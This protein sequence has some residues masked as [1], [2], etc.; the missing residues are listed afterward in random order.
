MS[1]LARQQELLLQALFEW[2]AQNAMKKIAAHAIDAGA[3][4][5]KA[6]QTNGHMLAE[7][8][9][10]AA[11]PVVTQVVGTQSMADLSRALWHAHPPQSGDLALWG[12]ELPVFLEHSEQL[13]DVPFLADVSRAEWALHRCAVAPDGVSDLASFAL[14]TQQDPQTLGMHLAPGCAAIQSQWPVASILGAHVLQTPSFDEV[15]QQLAHRVAQDVIVWRTGFKPLFKLAQIGE[16]KCLME[17]ARGES[18]L[19]A[20]D[21][22][23]EL[24]FSSWL[25]VAVQSGLVL[26]VFSLSQQQ[27]RV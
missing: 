18:L 4:G 3:R 15:G 24:D 17:L 12:D 22:S 1:N 5:L 6:Y 27:Q 14:L 23:P 9:L 13:S 25:P 16:A 21:A 8:A 10:T 19:A 7:R 11:F 20:L 26:S 2:P